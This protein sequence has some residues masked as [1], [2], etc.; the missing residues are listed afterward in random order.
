MNMKD[1]N[2]L[3]HYNHDIASLALCDIVEEHWTEI[4]KHHQRAL[5]TSA[6]SISPLGSNT[7]DDFEKKALF[8]RCYML[9]DTQS[10]LIVRIERYDY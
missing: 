2:I 5:A 6:V 10:P 4:D 8:G 7:F 1:G 9:M 3:I